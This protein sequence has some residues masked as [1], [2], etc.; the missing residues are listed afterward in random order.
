MIIPVFVPHK[1]CPNDCI[2]CNQKSISGQT[3]EMAGARMRE[4][5]E[6]NL[7]SF[8]G[9]RYIEIA[10]YGGSFTGID[11][12]KQLELLE[13]G[14]YYVNAGFVREM[15]LSTRPD[16]IN[17]DI[18]ETLRKYNVRTIEIGVQSLD[19]E[20]LRI[21]QRGHGIR[22][23]AEAARLIKDYGFRLGIQTM[24]GLP[25]DTREKDIITAQKVVEFNPEVVRI[26]PT[27][28]IKNTKLESMYKNGEYSPL[29]VDE[30]VDICAHL[31]EI[32]KENGI[33][34]IR[35]G[36]Q[37]TEEIREGAEVVAGPFHPAF[38]Q[39]VESRLMLK[40]IEEM[41]ERM[42]LGGS[43]EITVFAPEKELSYITGQKRC[44]I[45]SLKEKYGFS[46]IRIIKSNEFR[47]AN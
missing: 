43:R 42:Q 13:T 41:I 39:L 29:T 31:L 9:G 45:K 33:N 5:V 8:T 4:I 25:G 34:V 30:A 6:R 32:Y 35:I 36:L 14:Q 47:I 17:E 16:Y 46:K 15:R 27:L 1:G 24:I 7:S 38:R 21:S 44:N 11:K 22:E 10:F 20:V 23:V 12:R 3:E 2:Y 18:L 26:Y 19:S 28:V 40:K 37:P